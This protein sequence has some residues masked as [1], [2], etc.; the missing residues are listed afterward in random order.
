[1]IPDFLIIG[2]GVV[3]LSTALELSGRGASVALL[4]RSAVGGESSWAGGGIL[5]PLLP[6]D[7]AGAVNA[8]T[9]AG[10]QAFP[11]LCRSL[12][13][14]TGIDPEYRNTG[15]LVLPPFDGR[16]AH[17]WC[18][19]HGWPCEDRD[20]GLVLGSR[21]GESGLWLPGVSQVRNPRLLQALA[22]FLEISGVGIEEQVEVQGLVS[23]GGKITGV[24]TSRGIREGSACI[25]TGGAWSATLP[26]LERLRS[27][28]YPIRGQMLLYRA[29]ENQLPCIVLRDGRYLIPR[30]DGHILAGSTVEDVGFD[31]STTDEAR[32]GLHHFACRLLPE[33]ERADPIRHWSGLRPGSPENIPVIDRHPA[34][35]NLYIN[36]GH[37]R[38]GVTMAPAAASLMTDLI[39]GKPP[40]LDPVPYR[41][42]NS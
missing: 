27:R 11:T 1:L 39:V 22:K 29:E 32:I 25:V 36:A 19:A 5:S 3:G 28:I 20:G 40:S 38:Y 10:R 34:F 7:Y 12:V 14:S 2:A 21:K 23:Q 15:M 41:Y 37:F 24:R 35:D 4:E 9:E 13:E 17:P 6:W 42:P 16:K 8:L 26:E 31:K 18:N 33:L 30:A